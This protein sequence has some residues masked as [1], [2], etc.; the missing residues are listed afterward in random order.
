MSLTFGLG[1]GPSLQ[2]PAGNTWYAGNYA[3]LA[4]AVNACASTTQNFRIG[5][6]SLFPGIEGPPLARAPFILRPYDQ[7]LILCQ[8][9]LQK[10]SQILISGYNTAGGY[11]F[12]E[13]WFPTMRITPAVTFITPTY[14]NMSALTNNQKFPNHVENYAAIVATGSGYAFYDMTLDARL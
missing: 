9:Q 8:R 3:S 10:F 6:V 12:H 4:S 5:G 11:V 14:N 13:T 2:A 1:Y 7:E